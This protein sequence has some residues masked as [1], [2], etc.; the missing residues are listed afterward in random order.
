MGNDDQ[1][2]KAPIVSATLAADLEPEQI[3]EGPADLLAKFMDL[4]GSVSL[5]EFVFD[6]G[7]MPTPEPS[8]S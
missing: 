5:E 1:S 7:P 2:K 3:A 4:R 6:S 8:C